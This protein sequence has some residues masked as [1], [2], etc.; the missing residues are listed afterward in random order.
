MSEEA[1]AR[2]ESLFLA[3]VIEK[4]GKLAATLLSFARP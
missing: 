4:H 3:V 2:F 1:C